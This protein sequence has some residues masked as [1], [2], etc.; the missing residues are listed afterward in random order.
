[1]DLSRFVVQP[2]NDDGVVRFL[3]IARML[4][5]KGVG[6][7]VEA[8]R[9]LKARYGD[10]VEFQL[11]GFLGVNN[12]SAVSVEQMQAWC[13]EG[14]VH[15]L[16]VSDQVE[17]VIAQ[18]DCVVLPSY[19]REGVPKSLLEAAAMG[20]PLIT[21]DNIGCRETVD[22]GVNGFLCQ[23]QSVESLVEVLEKMLNLSHAQ[24]LQMGE[25]S[26]KKIA[27]EFDE[28]VVI[29]KYLQAIKAH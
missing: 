12:P 5:D 19:Y 4:F 17:S 9:Q 26:R 28:R 13:D 25:Q 21:T 10:A 20:K 14:I 29:E 2:A 3:L 15:Y 27:R 11:L 16:G 1:M 22:D 18:A 23:M 7:Y 24:R 6:I 8:A